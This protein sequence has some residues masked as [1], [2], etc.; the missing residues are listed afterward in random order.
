MQENGAISVASRMTRLEKHIE[1]HAAKICWA[2]FRS[3]GAKDL[4]IK[5]LL[6]QDEAEQKEATL[7]DVMAIL[8]M[9][10]KK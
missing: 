3:V 1:F 6:P 2:I 9:A 8:R 10:R 7:S 4:E 5:D